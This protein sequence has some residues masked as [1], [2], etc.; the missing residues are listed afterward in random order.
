MQMHII[1]AIYH[2]V[3]IYYR[4]QNESRGHGHYIKTYGRVW[5]SIQGSLEVIRIVLIGHHYERNTASYTRQ[6]VHRDTF[7]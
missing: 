6:A 4:V 3:V 2:C 1:E 7:T 5:V